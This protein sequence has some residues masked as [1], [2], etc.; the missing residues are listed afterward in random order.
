MVHF[1]TLSFVCTSS[2]EIGKSPRQR[3]GDGKSVRMLIG[4]HPELDDECADR[5]EVTD[6]IVAEGL[7]VYVALQSAGC[8]FIALPEV[9]QWLS[10]D[11]SVRLGALCSP[12]MNILLMHRLFVILKL[13]FQA[14]VVLLFRR[15]GRGRVLFLV[16]ISSLAMKTS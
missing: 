4:A 16:V 2:V 11:K 1:L 8:I 14:K 5:N 10:T 3:I 13:S 12:A 15:I 9:N 7:V 6:I